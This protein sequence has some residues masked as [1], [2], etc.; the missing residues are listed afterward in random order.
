[1]PFSTTISAIPS[2]N[3]S[4]LPA[5]FDY[6]AYPLGPD[7]KP[8]C[9]MLLDEYCC[10]HR[11]WLPFCYHD[12]SVKLKVC[13]EE[14]AD[15]S[16]VLLCAR[17]AT[18]HCEYKVDLLKLVESDT[19]VKNEGSDNSLRSFIVSDSDV[20]SDDGA[21]MPSLES[22][23]S[24]SSAWS[25]ASSSDASG[26]SSSDSNESSGDSSSD[27]IDL[28]DS[29]E[30]VNNILPRALSEITNIS[31]IRPRRRAARDIVNDEDKENVPPSRQALIQRLRPARR[32][33]AHRD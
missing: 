23:E 22:D 16:A 26:E 12:Q 11:F 18:Q 13:D 4:R 20:D 31:F 30:E 8:L 10:S 28:I 7:G 21:S 15:P 3:G 14:G 24:S 25:A 9:P 6:I 1:M 17:E 29:P 33:R 32:G 2:Y 27:P 19:L 5:R